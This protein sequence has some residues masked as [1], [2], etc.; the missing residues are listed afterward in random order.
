MP[1]N[2]YRT[3]YG[4][5]L[6]RYNRDKNNQPEILMVKKRYTYSFFVFV[7]GRYKKYDSKYLT[8]LF[9]NM[10]HGEKLDILSLD[11]GKMW[12]RMWLCSPEKDYTMYNSNTKHTKNIKYYFKK[13]NKFSSIFLKDGGKRLK[14]L[15]HN[16]DN[17]VSP[18]EI[19]KGTL[20]KNETILSCAAREFE[21]E[22][23]I[24]S[25]DYTILYDIKPVSA[26]H[27][28]LKIIYKQIYYVAYLNNDSNWVPKKV[29]EPSQ[30]NEIEQ[31]KWISVN[32]IKFLDL[33]A[34]EKKKLLTL[35]NSVI[36]N[37]KKHV[38]SYYY[39]SNT[40]I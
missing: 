40:D 37:F 21:E 11:F 20:E 27:K 17:V 39:V 32:E 15:V 5:A 30:I 10:T 36:R 6:C 3:S 8:Q 7:F 24:S 2:T 19:P 33:N 12:Y 28:E 1:K 26:A 38:K 31:I 29:F 9:N 14:Q 25:N 16:S 13:K 22:T 23:A 35:C 4:I 34:V 18:W